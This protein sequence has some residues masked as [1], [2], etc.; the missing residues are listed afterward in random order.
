MEEHTAQGFR[1]GIDIG[2]TFTDVVLLAR[3]RHRSVTPQGAL[4]ARRLRARRRRGRGGA[5]RRARASPPAEIDRRRARARR[6]RLEHD[7]RGQRRAHGADHHRRLPRRARD[8][9]AAHPGALRPPVRPA[10]A[11]RAAPPAVRG[12]PS[13]LGPRG[14]VWRRARRGD[15][16]IGVAAAHRATPDVEAVAIALLHSY[17]D[18]RTSGA[19]R[20]SCGPRLGDGVYVT[21]LVRRPARDPR[22]RAHEHGGRQRLRRPGRRRATSARS[23]TGCGRPGS[24]A[25]LE[26]MQSS[27]GMMTPRAARASRP[28]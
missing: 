9:P 4:D 1:L 16:C 27:G 2:G 10:A 12:R 23:S 11:A 7:P 26:V 21:L 6:S 22:V 24:T 15:A 8:A 20:R 28:T 25:P 5:A 14:E 13:A 19:S 3:R 18:P 17:V